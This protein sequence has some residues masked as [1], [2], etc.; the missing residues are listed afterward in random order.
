MA[1]TPEGRVKAKVKK[2][3]DSYGDRIW[4]FLPVS[5]GFGKHGI[6]D[7]IVC[8]YGHFIGIECKADATKKPTKLQ[9]FTLSAIAQADGTTLVI[10]KDNIEEVNAAVDHVLE[11]FG[12]K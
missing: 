12:Y 8:A 1:Q 2:V 7:F 9:Q 3:L 6:P 10:H 11:C 4:Y 5:G